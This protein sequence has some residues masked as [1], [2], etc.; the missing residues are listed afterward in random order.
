MTLPDIAR[1]AAENLLRTRLR[2]A[3][4]ALGVVIGIGALISMMSFGL[5]IQKNVTDE[6]RRNDLFTTLEVMP[7][8]LDLRAVMSGNAS[9]LLGSAGG[10][11]VALDEAALGRIA[12]LEG[13]EIAFPEI[14]F[15]VRVRLGERE[16]ETYVQALP[17]AMGAYRPFS[18]LPH[19]RFFSDDH[20]RAAIVG[21]GR[22]PADR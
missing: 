8:D 6:L 5:G 7:P 2:T 16:A 12:A 13:V 21:P 1:L 15:P 4:T 18:D 17:A 3:L 22:R 10:T 19:G 11:E 20:E 14:R 9:S